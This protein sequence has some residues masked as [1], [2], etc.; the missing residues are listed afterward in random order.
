MV[1]P[2]G[3]SVSSAAWRS[4][5]AS[6]P[7]YFLIARGSTSVK[8]IHDWL[9]PIDT[10]GGTSSPFTSALYRLTISA[11]TAPRPGAR[12]FGSSSCAATGS[13]L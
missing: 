3:M 4:A 6:T 11:V 8:K 12:D 10:C 9:K 7:P 2:T 5:S 13:T 1:P